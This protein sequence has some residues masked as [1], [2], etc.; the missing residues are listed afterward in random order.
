LRVQRALLRAVAWG[1]LVGGDGVHHLDVAHLGRDLLRHRV[2]VGRIVQLD[3]HDVG[4]QL[5]ARRTADHCLGPQLFPRPE[6]HDDRRLQRVLPPVADPH[7]AQLVE[8]LPGVLDRLDGEHVAHLDPRPERHVAIQHGLAALAAAELATLEC[9]RLT[10]QPRLHADQGHVQRVSTFLQRADERHARRADRP[11]RLDAVDAADLVQAG[12]PDP[13]SRCRKIH[14][15]LVDDQVRV[16]LLDVLPVAR[17]EP[18]GQRGHEQHQHGDQGDHAAE[19]DKAALCPPDFFDGQ[20][21]RHTSSAH[22][23]LIQ[24]IYIYTMFV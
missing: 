21:K 13:R 1:R 22:C 17:A 5:R 8:L 15:G 16:Q 2:P 19:Q 24:T 11:D 6:G 14:V 12:H 3:R 9:R 10:R 20:V 18:F 4:H 7:H 23:Y